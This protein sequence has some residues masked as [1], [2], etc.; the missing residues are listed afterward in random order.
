MDATVVSNDEAKNSQ[1]LQN[2]LLKLAKLLGRNR[3]YLGEKVDWKK[4]RFHLKKTGFSWEGKVEKTE[5]QYLF[6]KKQDLF[7][8]LKLKKVENLFFR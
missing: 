5:K 3:I 7:C 2:I 1:R 6:E 4:N 8:L